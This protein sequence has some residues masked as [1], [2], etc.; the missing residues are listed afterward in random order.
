MARFRRRFSGRRRGGKRRT[1]WLPQSDNPAVAT[2]SSVAPN[3]RIQ[4]YDFGGALKYADNLGAGD[5][6]IERAPGAFEATNLGAAVPGAIRICFGIGLVGAGLSVT[7][8]GAANA[9]LPGQR[10][11]LSWM[12][13]ACCVVNLNTFEVER[14]S[15][16]GRAKRRIW[17][18]TKIVF[19]AESLDAIP[20][21]T[22][23]DVF[24]NFR[25]LLSQKGSRV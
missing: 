23:V 13:Y 8:A 4:L 19:A 17:N 3:V 2:L 21:G 16:E 24:A 12:L 25:F 14:C 6:T 18:E 7:D 10:P 20:A 1:V 5:W 22:E 15:L 9:Q 11:E